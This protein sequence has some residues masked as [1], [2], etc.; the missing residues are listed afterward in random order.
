MVPHLRWIKY[1]FVEGT[2]LL[3]S[4]YLDKSCGQFWLL[5]LRWG[6][7]SKRSVCSLGLLLGC[8]VM[9]SKRTQS[10][11]PIREANLAKRWRWGMGDTTCFEIKYIISIVE[12][13][14]SGKARSLQYGS[15]LPAFWIPFLHLL[16][17]CPK[18]R[19]LV[20]KEYLLLFL[21][22]LAASSPSCCVW[23]FCSTLQASPG[24]ITTFQII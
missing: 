5:L 13:V 18:F 11:G 17:S 21:S 24:L 20:V 1:R 9:E 2:C 16:L 12:L 3:D 14:A 7:S 8:E 4:F 10:F 22:T 15:L 6:P 23:V 19:R